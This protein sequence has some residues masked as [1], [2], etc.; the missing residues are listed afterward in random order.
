MTSRRPSTWT[1][2][3]RLRVAVLP[4]VLLVAATGCRQQPEES[5]AGPD[6]GKVD[7]PISC[8]T[9]AQTEFN[10]AVALLHHMTYPQARAVF[11]Q[12]ATIDP[13]CAMAH[14]GVAMT[15][16]QPLWPTRPGPD[17]LERGRDEVR[18]ARALH[19]PTDRERLLVDAAGA[20]FAEPESTDYWERIRRWEQAM[21]KTYTAFPDDPEV[22]AFYALAHLATAP[23]DAVSHEHSDRAAAILLAIYE[24]NPEHPGAMHY[25]IHANDVPGRE[26][27]SLEIV[28]KYETIAPNNP[29]ALHMPTHIYTRLGDWD[30]VIRGNLRAAEA[31]LQHPAGDQGEFVWDEFPHAIEYL[32]YA[33]LQKGQDEEAEAQMDRLHATGTLQPTFKTAFHLASTRARVALERHD[34]SE[35]MSLEPRESKSVDWDR[36]AWP[37]AIGWFARGLGAAH[38]GEIE[39]ARQALER[40]EQLEAQSSRTGEVLFTRNIHVLR[41]TVQAWLAH[42]MKNED[43]SLAVMREAADFEAATPKHPVTPGPTLPASELLGDLLLDQG[44][45]GEALAAY[46]RSL[47]LY[48]GRLNSLLGAARAAQRSGGELRARDYYRQVIENA[49]GGTRSEILEEAHRFVPLEG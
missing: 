13:G 5:A 16:F 7:F 29:H 20:F 23:S 30:A 36:F 4:V 42:A 1:S 37:E 8:S 47:V 32:V 9:E 10:R 43:R 3:G 15:L 44:R 2:M 26:H 25:L 35:A 22:A 48:P 49:G 11:Q 45:S 27:E 17:E 21:E 38:Q 14:W 18:Q 33:Y 46:E 39:S 19:P 12:V 24:K 40:L 6:L 28:R 31:A 41:L 34:W